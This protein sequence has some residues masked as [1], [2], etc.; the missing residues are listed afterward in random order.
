MPRIAVIPGDGVGPEVVDEVI[1]VLALLAGRG[2]PLS[3]SRFDYGAERFLRKGEALPEGALD[4]LRSFDAI[5]LGA[6]GD[7]RIPDSAHARG[8]LLELR[9]R[10]DLY[11]NLRPVKVYDASL[12][13]L[14]DAEGVD[15]AIVRENTE[16]AYA[17]SGGFL[18]KGTPDEADW[19]GIPGKEDPVSSPKLARAASSSA[20]T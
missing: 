20:W 19:T 3:W 18:R 15:F 13:P 16:G 2:L 4:E 12:S 10:L 17:G 6:L 9:F 8:I 11:V 14:R 7:P 5:F 1:K